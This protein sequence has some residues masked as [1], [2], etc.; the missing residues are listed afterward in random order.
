MTALLLT[1]P[2][3]LTAPVPKELKQFRTDLEA[4]AGEWEVVEA[5]DYGRAS[6]GSVGIR[7][8]IDGASVMIIPVGAEKPRGPVKITLNE[9]EKTY[10]WEAPWGTWVGRYQID[11]D[12]LVMSAVNKGKELPTDVKPN[13]KSEYTLLKRSPKK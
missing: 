13:D 9:K 7:Y 12:T 5:A 4:L 1:I 8:S 6:S 11:K 3:A 2:L 10:T